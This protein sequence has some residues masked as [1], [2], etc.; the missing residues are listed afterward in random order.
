M[1]LVISDLVLKCLNFRYHDIQDQHRVN[2]NNTIK[3][4]H[5]ESPSLVQHSQLYISCNSCYSDFCVKISKLSLS[6][7]QGWDWSELQWHQWI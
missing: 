6:S 5:L 4:P 2:L 3:S 1:W 7:Q